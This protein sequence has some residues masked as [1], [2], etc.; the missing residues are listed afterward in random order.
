LFTHFEG[1]MKKLIVFALAI[2]LAGG[3]LMAQGKKGKP[4]DAEAMVKKA[5]AFYK[6]NGKEKAVA[7]FNDPKGKFVDGDL[8]ILCYDLE[9]NCLAHGSNPKM[10]GKNWMEL[11][12]ADGKEFVKERMKIAKEKGK[13]WQDYK[14]TNPLSKAI[15]PKTLYLERVDDIVIGCGAYK[16]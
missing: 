1:T 11:K 3:S 2:V 12:D 13:G 15:E 10:V 6:A 8:Y 5:I 4:A 14:W 7:A 9:G 16:N